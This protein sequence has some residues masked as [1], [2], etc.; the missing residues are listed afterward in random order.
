MSTL[1][2][3]GEESSECPLCM[4]PLEMDDL[5]FYPCTCGYQVCFFALMLVAVT[6]QW[7]NCNKP[8]MDY[9][10]QFHMLFASTVYSLN[11]PNYHNNYS[12]ITQFA[13]LPLLLA[14]DK[15]R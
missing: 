2:T 7:Y 3:S 10:L 11:P 5:S 1:N 13:D 15:D 6:S 14:S 9:C 12:F 4:E 8:E